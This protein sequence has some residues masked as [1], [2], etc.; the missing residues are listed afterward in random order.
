VFA[1]MLG[2]AAPDGPTDWTVTSDSV[3]YYL[4]DPS[5]QQQWTVDPRHWRVVRYTKT[6]SNGTLLEERRFSEFQTTQG[7]TLPHRVI[8]QRPSE[9]LKARIDYNHIQLNPSGLS[10]ALGVPT[11]VPRKPL[12]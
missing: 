8:F 11:N 9:N 7:V 4:S 10:F 12:R 2:L 5:G 3:H 1:N 6:D